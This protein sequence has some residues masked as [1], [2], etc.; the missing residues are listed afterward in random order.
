MELLAAHHSEIEALCRK[1]GV[2]RL[3]IFGSALRA[4]WDATRSDFDFVADFGTPP[5]G[6]NL[7][8]QQFGL[9]AELERVLGRPVDVVDW[10]VNEKPYFREVVE[11]T[12]V[13][14]Y[15]A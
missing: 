2:L 13:E 15:A 11:T 5:D 10:A 14:L 3:R 1:Y 6:I 7:F 4:D 12:A 9:I 8:R